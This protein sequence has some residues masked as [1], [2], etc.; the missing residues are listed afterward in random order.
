MVSSY[1]GL[2]EKA[3]LDYLGLSSQ[4]VSSLVDVTEGVRSPMNAL[5]YNETCL[6]DYSSGGFLENMGTQ[7][8]RN[9]IRNP[10]LPHNDVKISRKAMQ[11]KN[12]SGYIEPEISRIQQ[13]ESHHLKLLAHK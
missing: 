8:D 10:S 1:Y 7:D 3:D 4:L 6:Q 2:T 13:S 5:E 11:M 9:I 12:K